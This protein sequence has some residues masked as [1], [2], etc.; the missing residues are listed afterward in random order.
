M[1]RLKKMNWISQ[2]Q[3]DEYGVDIIRG[4]DRLGYDTSLYKPSPENQ[5]YSSIGN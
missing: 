2:N 4:A 1:V 3:F 5:K